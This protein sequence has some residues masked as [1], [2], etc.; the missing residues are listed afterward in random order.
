ME[1]SISNELINFTNKSVSE[2]KIE[3][4]ID[5]NETF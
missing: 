2:K 4:N 5:I 1:D 3:T